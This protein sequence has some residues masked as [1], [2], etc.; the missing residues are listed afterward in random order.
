MY[1]PKDILDNI[2]KWTEKWLGSDFQ[3]RKYQKETVLRTLINILNKRSRNTIINAP[4]G[5]GK[6]I[7]AL[8]IAGVASEYY[9]K[10]AYILVSDT[11]LHEQYENAINKFNLPY[12]N[13]KGRE[14]NYICDRNQR[15]VIC[16]ECMLNNISLKK[17]M[18]FSWVSKHKEYYCAKTCKWVLD[19]KKA[20]ES[21]VS[22][23][24]YQFWMYQIHQVEESPFT[25]R[26][27]VIYDECHKIPDIV[28]SLCT[29]RFNEFDIDKLKSI[30]SH[31]LLND[32]TDS[33]LNLVKKIKQINDSE[34]VLSPL[35]APKFVK[36]IKEIFTKLKT[37]DDKEKQYSLLKELYTDFIKPCI[38]VRMI[39]SYNI[40][41]DLAQ[42]EHLT[43]NDFEIL[44][45][46]QWFDNFAIK[47]QWLFDVIDNSNAG[48]ST[49]IRE[50]QT[51]EYKT[52][53]LFEN[54]D[55]YT[56]LAF[57]S[58]DESYIIWD[59][60][61]KHSISHNVLMSATVGD[62]NIYTQNLGLNFYI[63]ENDIIY[64]YMKIN[65]IFDFSRSNINVLP[66][67]RMSYK[68]KDTSLPKLV[69]YIE[70]ICNVHKGQHG[71]LHTGSY[72]ITKKLLDMVQDNNVKERLKYYNTTSEKK[73]LIREI[74]LKNDT[75]ITGPSLIEGIDLPD[76]L[77]RFMI[78]LKV[79]YPSLGSEYVKAK[80]KY[81]DGWYHAQTV[82]QL[83][84]CIGRGVRNENDWCITYILDGCFMGNILNGVIEQDANIKN[85]LKIY[86]NE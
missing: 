52:N 71:I 84:Q 58:I 13:I 7:T 55:H 18:D 37:T 43:K 5:S 3:F 10:S 41:Q 44:E 23:L 17:L 33:Q 16:S 45:K 66:F 67:Y 4:T 15:D 61:L 63:P 39:Y 54:I 69:K 73:D 20:I 82:N 27:I 48:V 65:S 53:S 86:L 21:S 50:I 80:M 62:I 78:I 8:I 11:Y 74:N 31:S 49:L 30:Q 59:K 51:L 14:N 34:L 42:G 19:R 46:F 6:S 76:D 9:Q 12:G 60:L 47:F 75:V 85:R 1:N 68:E 64:D 32:Y 38:A 26:D 81:I 24:T 28:Q 57:C 79:P 56:E 83:I 29:L 40:E 22:V 70:M 77:C 2:E 72:E 35:S 36:S 25:E